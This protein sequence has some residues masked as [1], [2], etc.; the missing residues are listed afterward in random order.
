MYHKTCRE[1]NKIPWE[2]DS[3]YPRAAELYLRCYPN[4]S[5]PKAMLANY[6][7]PCE[8]A[9]DTMQQR[10]RRMA[11]DM[12]AAVS[13][14]RDEI[15][16][17]A[18]AAEEAGLRRVAAQRRKEPVE[19]PAVEEVWKPKQS[20]RLPT[21][22][23]TDMQNRATQNRII[24]KA[25]IEG[26][27][28]FEE[29]MKKRLDVNVDKSHILSASDVVK[30]MENKYRVKL[31]PRTIQDYVRKG[32]AGQPLKKRGP[33]PAFLLPETFNFLVEAYKTYV[34]L[35]RSTANLTS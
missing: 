8:S 12:R 9:D 2:Q 21:Q 5:V 4:L 17:G 22:V 27:L 20:R 13:G 23:S 28:V 6:F 30:I 1:L 10:V 7:T 3:R 33:N 35:H 18:A 31:S 11:K 29:Q 26:C 19:E 14:V 16:A 24:N 32:L 15:A 25:F 34:Q